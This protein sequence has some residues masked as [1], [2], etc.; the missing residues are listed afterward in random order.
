MNVDVDLGEID[1]IDDAPSVVDS[2]DPDEFLAKNAFRVVYQTNNFLL[3]QI[4]DMIDRGEAINLHPEY[5]RRLRWNT[6][7]K[8]RLIESLLLNIPIP[9]VFFYENDAAR[10]EVMDGQ[11]RLNTIREFFSGAFALTGLRVLSPL[12]GIRYPKAPPRVKRTLDRASISAIVLLMESETEITGSNLLNLTDIRRL[13]FDRLNTGGMKLN[14]Q[15]L[16]NAQNPG[17]FNNAIVELSRYSLFTQVFGIPAYNETNPDDYYINPERQK[18][19]LYSTMK[20]CELVLR[21][22]ALK[23][24][25][26]IRGSMKSMLDRAMDTQ[27]TH[28]QAEAAKVEFKSRFKFLFD[29]FGGEPFSIKAPND[30]RER[31][32]AAVYDAAMVAVNRLW[33]RRNEIAARNA[34]IMLRLT[35]AL[36]NPTEYDILVGRGNTAES[37]R[38]RISLFQTILL[39]S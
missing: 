23:N 16:R 25:A 13:V 27:M 28:E 18:N 20:D 35:Q 30:N 39:A 11:Q 5:Q 34:A 33:D 31:V 38:D 6:T 4:R 12:N 8:S 29:L 7:Q 32:S 10:Y 14:A 9:P 2:R 15:E 36:A 26:N 21:Y 17:P 19:S 3:P 37:V 24:D 1:E 22:F